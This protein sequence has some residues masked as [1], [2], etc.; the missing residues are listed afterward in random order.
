M[1]GIY[2]LVQYRLTRFLCLDSTLYIMMTARSNLV[3]MLFVM[4][5]P[6]ANCLQRTQ[7]S[8]LDKLGC[9]DSV[10]SH[11]MSLK[12]YKMVASGS[13]TCHYGEILR[14]KLIKW[15]L[16]ELMKCYLYCLKVHFVPY[17]MRCVIAQETWETYRLTFFSHLWP[18]TPSQPPEGAVW[19]DWRQCVRQW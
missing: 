10:S 19:L 4:W 14:R 12:H 7:L 6:L 1:Y 13:N 15:N 9:P 2:V 11:N 18:S 8:F 3:I 16:L 17:Y 5:Q